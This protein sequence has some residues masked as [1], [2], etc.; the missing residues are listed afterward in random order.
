MILNQRCVGIDADHG[1]VCS[2]ILPLVNAPDKI[3]KPSSC[4]IYD[5]D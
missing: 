2:L 1:S 3:K 5:S 4:G